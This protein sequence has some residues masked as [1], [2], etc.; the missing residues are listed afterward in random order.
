[1][2]AHFWPTLTAPIWGHIE[3]R[4][5]IC[6]RDWYW[7]TGL[8]FIKK[9]KWPFF[10]AGTHK[11]L[12]NYFLGPFFVRIHDRI[13][14]YTRMEPLIFWA[15]SKHIYYFLLAE[16]KGL[17]PLN[18]VAPSSNPAPNRFLIFLKYIFGPDWHKNYNTIF[19]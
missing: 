10:G 6:M 8:A 5:H 16:L 17:L 15:S 14:S 12:I 4:V 3:A 9:Y 11:K 13:I 19:D 7:D 1:M 2:V 18:T